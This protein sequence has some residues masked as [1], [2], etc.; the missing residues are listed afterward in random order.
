M[1]PSPVNLPSTCMSIVSDHRMPFHSLNLGFA[2]T[3]LLAR[4]AIRESLKTE[5]EKLTHAVK[6]KQGTV[7]LTWKRE[8][9]FSVRSK[10]LKVLN[11]SI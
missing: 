8:M 11:S 7:K 4:M 1:F 3:F 6:F 2:S 10:N 9:T 5:I